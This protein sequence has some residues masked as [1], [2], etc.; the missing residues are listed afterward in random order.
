MSASGSFQKFGEGTLSSHDQVA[1]ALGAEIISGVYPPGSKIPGEAEI[2]QRFGISRTVL[3]EVLKTLTAKGLIVS[4]TRVGTKVLEPT[5]WNLFDADVLSWKMSQG[6]DE[7]FH[8]DLTEI[9]LA[10]EPRAA[11]LAAKRRDPAAIAELR[12]A[13]AAMD[14]AT[15]TRREFAEAD[16]AFHQAI[17][18]ASGNVLMRSIS[19]VIETALVASFTMSSP[20]DDPELHTHNVRSHEKIVDAIES[21]DEVAAADAMRAVI[22]NLAHWRAL[23]D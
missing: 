13:I 6:M 20:I 19:A 18:A 1:R 10:I 12:D 4:K 22:K 9:R 14:R 11:A 8:G 15:Q 23:S 21:G 2:L 3:R 7:A 17:G 5:S 16:L